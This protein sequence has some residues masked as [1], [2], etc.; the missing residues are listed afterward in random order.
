MITLFVGQV[1]AVAGKLTEEDIYIRWTSAACHPYDETS[2]DFF[3]E[4]VAELKKM[5][6]KVFSTDGT[7]E[8]M[9]EI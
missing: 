1:Y 8:G 5:G 2:Y 7:Q 9:H 3:K 6:F 4:E